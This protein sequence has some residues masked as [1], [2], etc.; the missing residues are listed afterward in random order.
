MRLTHDTRTSRGLAWP[1]DPWLTTVKTA[2]AGAGRRQVVT[3]PWTTGYRVE[4]REYVVGAGGDWFL[5]E[6]KHIWSATMTVRE[7]TTTGSRGYFGFGGS[8]DYGALTQ[9]TFTHSV[10]SGTW[11]V[12][13]L[14]VS[15]G[16]LRLGVQET[17]P[18]SDLPYAGFERWV[19]VVD[20]R[21]FPFEVPDTN[22]GGGG[23][24]LEWP[25]SG[26][27][28]TDRQEVSLALVERERFEWDAV[29]DETDGDTGMSFTDATD[30]RD[31]QYVY[32]VWAHND[33]GLSHH[34][35]RGDW[36]LNGGDPGGYPETAAYVPP[37][38]A[39]QQVEETPSNTPATGAP[40]IRGT[41]QVGET[42]TASTSGIAHGDGLDDVAHSYS[43]PL[44]GRTSPGP[45]APPTP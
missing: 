35:L 44:E 26:L 24:N 31:R 38:P 18:S 45:P 13:T 7:S 32:R 42:L 20:G 15:G 11:T 9:T 30:K 2:R 33:R 37:P 3:D 29:R 6:F 27:S 12:N 16:E 34:S 40:A 22:I 10:S 19:L 1:R 17:P 14:F 36:A 5:P 23:L 28:W 8:N 21:S 39:Q 43:G 41:P 4:R 25:N